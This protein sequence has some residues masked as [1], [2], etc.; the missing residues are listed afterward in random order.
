MGRR[1]ANIT[2]ADISRTCRAL[3][4]CG[5]TIARVMTG[6]D[7]VVFE[8]GDGKQHAVDAIVPASAKREI[9]L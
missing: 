7:G 2:E 3:Q 5:I 6:K 9:V 1:P 8:T 4:K